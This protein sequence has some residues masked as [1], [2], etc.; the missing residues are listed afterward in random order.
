MKTQTAALIAGLVVISAMTQSRRLL[1]ETFIPPR[2]QAS[3]QA[4]TAC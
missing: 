1:T 4:S 2:N 3:K